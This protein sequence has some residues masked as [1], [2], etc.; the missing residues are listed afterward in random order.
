MKALSKRLIL[1]AVASTLAIGIAGTAAAASLG[2]DTVNG[3]SGKAGDV[4]MSK[5]H[6]SI[7]N[8]SGSPTTDVIIAARQGSDTVYWV[9]FNARTNATTAT[10]IIT[11]VTGSF[12]VQVQRL[13]GVVGGGFYILPFAV[14]TAGSPAGK[15]L[16]KVKFDHG[17]PKTCGFT[18]TT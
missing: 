11:K 2:R 13:T 15:Y 9:D 4:S 14:G 12:L 16:V 17:P 8:D 6:C 1:I 7:A 18:A 5:A 10:V 3:I